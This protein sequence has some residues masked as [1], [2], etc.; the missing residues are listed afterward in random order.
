LG[1]KSKK[2]GITPT[3]LAWT[4]ANGAFRE[5]QSKFLKAHRVSVGNNDVARRSRL[6]EGRNGRPGLAKKRAR[7]ESSLFHLR[8]KHHRHEP[9]GRGQR[10][11]GRAI[12]KGKE[13]VSGTPRL[14]QKL[15]EGRLRASGTF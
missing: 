9:R 13:R 2:W 15:R 11:M 12:L 5:G 8:E 7:C 14:R 4:P 3:N 10:K 1:E 6:R